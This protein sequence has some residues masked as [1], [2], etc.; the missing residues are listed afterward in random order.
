MP[1]HFVS[2]SNTAVISTNFEEQTH[3]SM[4]LLYVLFAGLVVAAALL[5]LCTPH[6]LYAALGLLLVLLSMAAIY[7]L[8][9]ASFVAVAHIMVYGSGVLVLVL[10]STLMLPLRTKRADMHP[11]RVFTVL[12]A[13]LLGG[14]L[15]PLVGCAVR[16]LQQQGVA[17]LQEN[18]VT[19]LGL[20]LLGPYSLAF[21]WVGMNLLIAL[22]GAVYIM[23]QQ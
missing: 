2:L 23:R 22:V 8:Q 5:V 18:V 4:V 15:W 16:T 17:T 20:Q 10:F 19:G 3:P 21:E 1:A 9:G 12:V 6:V 11:N 14:C 7:F 13:G